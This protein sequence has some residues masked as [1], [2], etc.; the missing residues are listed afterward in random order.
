MKMQTKMSTKDIY[1]VECI[2]MCEVVKYKIW[3]T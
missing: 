1:D 2:Y 3:K